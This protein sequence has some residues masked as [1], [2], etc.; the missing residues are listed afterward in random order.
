MHLNNTSQYAIRI[1]SYIANYKE[2][3]LVR[4]KE[5]SETLEIPYKFL[6]KI[7]TNLVKQ[8]F[9]LSIQGREGGYKLARPAS[10][11]TILDVLD[12][13]NESVGD[14][15]CLL[16]IGLCDG[17]NKCGLHDQWVEPK[18]LIKKMFKDTTLQNLDGKNLKI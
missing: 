7:M 17:S 6:T 10:D 1:L 18:K 13:F 9:I 8:E 2:D 11:I 3:S 12:K 5:L 4:A 14:K 16:G 15:E